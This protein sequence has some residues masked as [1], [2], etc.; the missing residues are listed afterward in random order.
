MLLS[1]HAS[2]SKSVFTLMEKS[3][4]EWLKTQKVMLLYAHYSLLGKW[5]LKDI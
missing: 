3:D 1:L 2:K 5:V 4:F